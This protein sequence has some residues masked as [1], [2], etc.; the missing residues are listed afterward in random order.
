MVPAVW[1][2]DGLTTVAQD[3]ALV[4]EVLRGVP[5]RRITDDELP[6]PAVKPTPVTVK[7]KLSTATANTLE[8][9]IVS[10]V[11]PVTMAIAAEADFVASAMLVAVTVIALGEGA[12]AGAAY[13]PLALI[14]PHA[15]PAQP[16]PKT[17]L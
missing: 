16:T 3:V 7:G 8:G 6:L 10:I 5:S 17:P 11:G 4:Q 13:T 1:T 15:A 14:E 12:M 9:K 2:S